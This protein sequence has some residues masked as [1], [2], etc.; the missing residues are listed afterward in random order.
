MATAGISGA[1]AACDCTVIGHA[2]SAVAT[3]A[4]PMARERRAVAERI[5]AYVMVVV[6]L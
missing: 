4:P 5:R 1:K 3:S 6:S 2:N